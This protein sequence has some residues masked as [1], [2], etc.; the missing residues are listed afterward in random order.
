MAGP[1][2]KR[3]SWGGSAGDKTASRRAKGHQ[4]TGKVPP[5]HRTVGNGAA[6]LNARRML[7]WLFGDDDK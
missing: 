6:K 7:G 2:D 5:A 4:A 1:E 3:K